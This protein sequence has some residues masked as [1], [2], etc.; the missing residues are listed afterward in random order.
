MSA[1]NSRKRPAPGAAPILPVTSAQPAAFN[2]SSQEQLLRWPSGMT[3]PSAYSDITRNANTFM[4][5]AT[6]G[7]YMQQ[8]QQLLPQQSSPQQS[9]Q[10]PQP[11]STAI[12]RRPPNRALIASAPRP[13][14]DPAADAWAAFGDDPTANSNGGLPSENESIEVLEERAQRVKKEAQAKRKPIPPFVQKL[15]SF[16]EEQKNTELIRWSESGDSFIVLDED[17]FAKTLIPELFKHNNYASFVRQLN[18]Y[19]FHKRVGLSDNSMKASE[20][21]N[22]SPSEYSNPYFKRGH[23]NLLWLINKPKSGSKSKKGKKDDGDIDSDEDIG[24]DEPLAHMPGLNNQ[25]SRPYGPGS[26]E[27]GPLQKKDFQTIKDELSTLQTRQAQIS[28]VMQRLVADNAQLQSQARIFQTMHER[29]ENSINAIL[30]FLANVFRKSLEEQG[31]VQSVTELLASILPNG[32]MPQGSVVDVSDDFDTQRTPVSTTMNTP[33]KRQRL[34]PPIPRQASTS[35]SP[36]PGRTGAAMSPAHQASSSTPNSA[37]SGIRVGPMGSVTELLDTQNDLGSSNYLQQELQTNPQEGMLKI[38]HDTNANTPTS[39]S[40][41]DLPEV[42]AT[43][44]VNLSSDQRNR[45]LSIMSGQNHGQSNGTSMT[46]MSTTAPPLTSPGTASLSDQFSLP[47]NLAGSRA[48]GM[49]ILEPI[50]MPQMNPSMG[51]SFGGMS[52]MPDAYGNASTEGVGSGNSGNSTAGPSSSAATSI[53]PILSQIP[54]IPAPPSLHDI[55]NTQAEIEALQKLQ[56]EQNAKITDLSQLLGPLSPS[57]RV[58]GIEESEGAGGGGLGGG[59]S[60]GYF[61]LGQYLDP[62]AF[63]ED[64]NF[65]TGDLGGGVGN[66]TSNSM[67]VTVPL[68]TDDDFNFGFDDAVGKVENESPSPAG[69]EEIPRADLTTG[70]NNESVKRRRVS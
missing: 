28:K 41:I 13:T 53:S 25:Q 2:T 69:T 24:I 12:A 46:G 7:Q 17:E 31:G 54:S 49:P 61:D 68:S 47:T 6:P 39:T 20:R 38:I 57:G 48:S 65:A 15:S 3:D 29:H 34:L 40:G 10:Q 51:N 4:M 64:F 70:S 67:G 23:P 26:S 63:G 22:K 44:P 59:Q 37:H 55:S 52:V 8:P 5:S 43:T 56:D 14:F 60:P 27:L 21:K 30:N 58:P 42:A 62:T 32:Q 66:M 11:I 36:S 19:G 33:P 50:T 16:L 18:M 1:P 9:Q 35:S 45:V